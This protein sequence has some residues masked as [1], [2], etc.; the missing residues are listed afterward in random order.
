M[1][2]VSKCAVNTSSV[3]SD[4]EN[5]ELLAIF[6]NFWYLFNPALYTFQVEGNTPRQ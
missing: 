1:P 3:S 4:V 6:Q 5:I 2:S